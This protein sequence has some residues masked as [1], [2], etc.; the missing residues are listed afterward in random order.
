MHG[1]LWSH[2]A[3]VGFDSGLVNLAGGDLFDMNEVLNSGFGASALGFTIGDVGRGWA[4][5]AVNLLLI[6]TGQLS[7]LERLEL[8][9]AAWEKKQRQ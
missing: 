6:I 7:N 4:P 5:P 9:R 8:S 1:Q 2:I 3:P